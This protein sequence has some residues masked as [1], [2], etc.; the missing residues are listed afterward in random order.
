M[1]LAA[2][3]LIVAM[4]IPLPAV[5][6]ALDEPVAA[7]P[8]AAQGETARRDLTA[9][10]AAK[11]TADL[12]ADSQTEGGGAAPRPPKEEIS[13]DHLRWL[14][15]VELLITEEERQAF[16]GLVREYQRNAFIRTFWHSRDPYPDTARNE[17]RSRWDAR[18]DI[19][20]KLFGTLQGVRSRVLLLNGEPVLRCRQ[21]GTATDRAKKEYWFYDYSE[22]ET[23]KFALIFYYD[24][25]RRRWQLSNWS[26]DPRFGFTGPTL[27]P[28]KETGASS[29]GVSDPRG[30]QFEL[31][32][33]FTEPRNQP[34][35]TLSDKVARKLFST[36]IPEDCLDAQGSAA[37]II[38]DIGRRGAYAYQTVLEKIMTP[39]APPNR[40]WL[41]TFISF[42]TEVPEGGDTFESSLSVGFPGWYGQRTIFEGV[43]FVPLNEVE[44]SELGG[45]RVYN[46]VLNG[47]VLRGKEL[48][49]HFRYRFDIP[50]SSV[51]TARIPLVFQRYLRAGDYTLVLRLEE[52]ATGRFHRQELPLSVPTAEQTTALAGL[53]TTDPETARLLEEA[54][55]AIAAGETSVRLVKPLGEMLTG[56]MR[57]DTQVIGEQVDR[58]V[59]SLD[60]QAI[61]TKTEPPYSVELDLG[62]LPRLLTLRAAALDSAG[63]EVASDEL[64]IN[65]GG[66]R[67]VVRL[68]EP[69]RGGQFS[70]A[71]RVRATVEVPE[72]ESLDRLE[73]FL[74]ED[75]MATLYDKPWVHTLLLPNQEIA[76]VRAVAY[77][78]S[79]DQVEDAAFINAPGLVEDVDVQFVEL[80]TLV[81]GRDHRPVT[82]L[83][84]EDFLVRENGV[85]QEI[86]RFETV[87]NRSIRAAILLDTSA[88]MEENL[89]TAQ[90]AALAFFEQTV[91]PRDRLGL[92]T[93]SDRPH[94]AV[95]FTSDLATF[96]GGLAGLKC[97]GG[98]ALYDSVI[99]SLFYFDGVQ[100]QRALLVISDGEDERSRY[101]FEETLEYA[102][103]A[104]VT[105]YTIG[106]D[107]ARREK[108]IRR[109]LTRLAEETGGR[110]FFIDSI[111]ELAEV[112]QVIQEE[113]R[114]RF[115]IAYQSTDSET[116]NRFRAVEV[117]VEGR[118]LEA[119][120]LRG[121]FP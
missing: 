42:S 13:K 102:R 56:L 73:I 116:D 68:V 9:D 16:L 38:R 49:E 31:Q 25:Q 117:E 65:A 107:L 85:P 47:E 33:G 91:E 24:I 84:K 5:C 55:A 18:A 34:G 63:N 15:D 89:D 36:Q 97:E 2:S 41:P 67:F 11:P 37:E 76:Y 32:R 59:F 100:G 14:R 1:R 61:L 71:V 114:S 109:R 82:N 111:E 90:Q 88:S 39:P 28:K 62:L 74:N 69:R 86:R 99:Y 12:A 118:G 104:G 44:P 94:L 43:L 81:L 27:R 29:R 22:R 64:V 58:V 93:F 57:F 35:T 51:S 112:Y 21:V 70:S 54:N 105:L 80:Y 46:F 50:A 96:A 30:N 52:L 121:Y 113:L 98:T 79:G 119:T 23:R 72:G 17:L 108:G 7:S 77:L 110:G 8:Q 53:A 60:D 40:E 115:L 101:G 10:V 106:I 4:A 26:T 95:K 75:R 103:R 92:I 20:R 120:T 6:Q 19:A 78:T 83:R 48:F 3:A 87:K 45:H 66:Y